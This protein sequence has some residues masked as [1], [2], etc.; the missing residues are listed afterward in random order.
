MRI[1]IPVEIPPDDNDDDYYYGEI[2]CT[3]EY[4]NI[5]SM[6]RTVN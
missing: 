4:S 3:N 5:C 6:V 1:E 2:K